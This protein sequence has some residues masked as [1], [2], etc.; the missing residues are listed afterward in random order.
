[1]KKQNGKHYRNFSWNFHFQLKNTFSSRIEEPI[2]KKWKTG[3]KNGRNRFSS[4]SLSKFSWRTPFSVE[5]SKSNT[6][7]LKQ[8]EEEDPPLRASL[9]KIGE[10][11]KTIFFKD[12]WVK[13]CSI[14]FSFES[15]KK[16]LH[17]STCFIS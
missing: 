1:M 16:M 10:L 11:K 14:R 17:K 7:R 6:I 15:W 2:C 12:S 13:C 5:E 9:F 4:Q 8:T 3:S